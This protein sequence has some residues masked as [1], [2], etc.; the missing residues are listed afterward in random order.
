MI[1]IEPATLASASFIAANLRP[2][3][4]AEIF[5]QIPADTPTAVLAQAC[6]TQGE[7]YIAK[8]RGQPVTL[9]G[10]TPMTV[11]C[12]SVWA[13]GTRHLPRTAPAVGQFFLSAIVPRR[14]E[15]G[16]RTAEVRVMADHEQ[17]R[18]WIKAL[19]GQ[20]SS[21]PFEYGTGGERF[22]L[23]RWTVAGYR[24]MYAETQEL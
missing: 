13:F 12:F 21:F 6:I 4:R 5:C 17:A 2:E 20:Q 7:A 14:I 23:Y 10:T 18:D 3:D 24:S 8:Y 16:F 22:V 11:A 9:F 1:E 19:G 15:Q